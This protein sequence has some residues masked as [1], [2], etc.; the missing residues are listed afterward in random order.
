MLRVPLIGSGLIAGV[1]LMG[2]SVLFLSSSFTTGPPSPWTGWGAEASSPASN[3]PFGDGDGDGEGQRGWDALGMSSEDP[4]S[5]S[6]SDSHSDSDSLWGRLAGTMPRIPCIRDQFPELAE[7]GSPEKEEV[8]GWYATRME[9]R[10]GFD[11]PG[12]QNFFVL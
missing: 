4:D 5:T 7:S 10:T 1:L 3:R 11:W 2:A 6:D 9:G 12:I 8:E